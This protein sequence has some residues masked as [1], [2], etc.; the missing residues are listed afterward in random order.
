[1]REGAG[2]TTIQPFRAPYVTQCRCTRGHGSAPAFPGTRKQA[3]HAG[4]R[5]P[6]RRTPCSGKGRTSMNHSGEMFNVSASNPITWMG[7]TRVVAVMRAVSRRVFARSAPPPAA[8]SKGLCPGI[9]GAVW[10]GPRT[11]AAQGICRGLSNPAALFFRQLRKH[12]YPF[13]TAQ[14]LTS[15]RAMG[16]AVPVS[17]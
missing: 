14:S 10:T 7:K 9:P 4:E 1:V 13:R 17:G 5:T 11:V 6:Y 8:L 15:T 16:E 3:L 2:G 12:G